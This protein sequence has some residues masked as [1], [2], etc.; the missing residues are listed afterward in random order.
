EVAGPAGIAIEQ[1]GLVLVAQ[2]PEARAVCET[3][4][5]TDMAEGCAW[6][7]RAEAKALLT[8]MQPVMLEGALTSSVDIRVESRTA[9]PAL[10][11][12]LA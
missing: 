11:A 8:P 9:I 10:A 6:L 12:W 5:E 1:R 4:L 3:F 7:D 2:R